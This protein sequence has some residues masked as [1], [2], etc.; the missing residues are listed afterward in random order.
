MDIV[1]IGRIAES[2]ALATVREKKEELSGSYPSSYLVK[3]IK[4]LEAEFADPDTLMKALGKSIYMEV[5]SGGSLADALWKTGEELGKGLRVHRDSIP[6]A[7]F[8][9]EMA[10]FDGRDPMRS[11]STGCVV[12]VTERG[13]ELCD[14]LRGTGVPCAV[15][16]YITDDNDRCLITE[17]G[18]SFL[19]GR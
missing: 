14:E 12:C 8:A 4:G 2:A 18:K 13:G 17:A 9:I 1:L 3:G 19:T 11:D 15:I 6:A 10:E 5:I 16:G 7:Q